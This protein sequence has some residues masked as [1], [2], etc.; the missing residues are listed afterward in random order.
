[1]PS[2]VLF[3]TSWCG[4]ASVGFLLLDEDI[5]MM[6]LFADAPANAR[7][8]VFSKILQPS[9]SCT[10]PNALQMELHY[11]STKESTRFTV[12]LNNMR[13]M[14]VFDWLLAIQDFILVEVAN[15]FENGENSFIVYCLML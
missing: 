3:G 13:L 5:Q 9:K 7:P 14:G 15:P 12:L 4:K 6:H 11:R 8:N 2:Q 1:M 10:F